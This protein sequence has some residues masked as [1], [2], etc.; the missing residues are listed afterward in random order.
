MSIAHFEKKS[1]DK[2]LPKNFE[3]FVTILL[4][5]ITLTFTNAD[6]FLIVIV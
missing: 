3:F 1:H 6:I 2:Y 4:Q 5:E